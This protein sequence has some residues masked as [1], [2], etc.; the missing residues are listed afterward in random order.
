MMRTR[1]DT[2]IEA[3]A[4]ARACAKTKPRNLSA[5]TIAVTDQLRAELL[6]V[7]SEASGL[8]AA[9]LFAEIVIGGARNA[10][11]ACP[12]IPAGQHLI[13]SLRVTSCM[14]ADLILAKEAGR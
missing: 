12:E 13:H 7:L 5:R 3:L 6:D 2:H 14:V 1:E 4:S 11:A 9:I 8:D 10:E